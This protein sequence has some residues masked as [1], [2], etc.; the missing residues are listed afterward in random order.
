M[1]VASGDAIAHAVRAATGTIPIVYVG[2]DPIQ[3]GFATSLARPGGAITG[4]TVDAGIEIWGKR[5]QILKE[6]VPLASKVGLLD[7]RTSNYEQLLQQPLREI[8]QRLEIS[9]MDMTVREFDA[10]RISARVCENRARA[11]GRDHCERQR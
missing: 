5:L 4:V 6:V 1:I 3:A 9:L 7:L 11:S 2:G 10:V 8:S